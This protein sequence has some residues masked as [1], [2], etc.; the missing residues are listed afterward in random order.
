MA[1]G[2]VVASLVSVQ[3]RE[4]GKRLPH[5]SAERILRHI[6]L[7]GL[8]ASVML[9]YPPISMERRSSVIGTK[10]PGPEVVFFNSAPRQ[11]KL[12]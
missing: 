7:E 1:A 4:R 12:T 6:A 11:R 3:R 5:R 9:Y 2:Q 8:T 10:Q